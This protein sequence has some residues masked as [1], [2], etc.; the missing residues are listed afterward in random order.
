ML[1]SAGSDA[2]GEKG[3]TTTMVSDAGFATVVGTSAG[4]A[5][6]LEVPVGMVLAGVYTLDALASPVV[7]T[8]EVLAIAEPPPPPDV[9]GHR[10]DA[11][12]P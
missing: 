11:K 2:H 10:L 3:L 1:V 7:A 9:A 8:L 6:E 12:V 5:S 4:L